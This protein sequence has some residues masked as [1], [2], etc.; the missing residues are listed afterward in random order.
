MQIGR[1][2][3]F[4]AI[5]A[6]AGCSRLPVTPIPSGQPII[7]VS[8]EPTMI[9]VLSRRTGK[10]IIPGVD[11]FADG[12]CVIRTFAGKERQKKLKPSQVNALLEFFEREG[13]F[14]ISKES[15]EN[16]IRESPDGQ[17]DVVDANRTT[18]AVDMGSKK[19][20]ISRNALDEEVKFYRTVIELQVMK[21]CVERVY[22]D[23]KTGLFDL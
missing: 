4:S 19:T 23:V 6:L 14:R 2:I 1:L 10:D 5:V 11:I 9:R 18:I 17:I 21:K 7:S 16:A 13:L 12:R 20:R 3:L 15:I 22:A 8:E